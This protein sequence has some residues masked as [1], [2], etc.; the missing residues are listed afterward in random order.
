[1][2]KKLFSTIKIIEETNYI[3]YFDEIWIYKEF[4][5]ERFNCNISLSYIFQWFFWLVWISQLVWEILLKKE[6]CCLIITH[7]ENVNGF[8]NDAFNKKKIV[9]TNII[10][11]EYSKIWGIV[12]FKIIEIIEKHSM[13]IMNNG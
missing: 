2:K 7:I 5:I 3:D 8:L 4:N 9:I 6:N 10:E 13:I 11:N 1:M 12:F